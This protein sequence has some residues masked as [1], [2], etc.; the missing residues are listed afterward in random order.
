VTSGDWLLQVAMAVASAWFLKQGIELLVGREPF[1]LVMILFGWRGLAFV[2]RDIKT[3][4]GE[5]Y[6]ENYW[7]LFHLQRMIGAY[8]AAL[9]AFAVVN[10]PDRLSLVAWLLPTAIITPV[11]IRWSRKY[12]VP[13]KTA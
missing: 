8:I 13:V 2:Y 5:R 4:R 7:L 9:T 11:I 6:A 3:F 12:R 10:A 1:G